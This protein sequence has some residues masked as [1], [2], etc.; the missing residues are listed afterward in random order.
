M[1]FYW[2][3]LLKKHI[4]SLNTLSI[5]KHQCLE[6]QRRRCV[7]NLRD[8]RYVYLLADGIYSS[9]RQNDRLC[10]LLLLDLP[11]LMVRIVCC[12]RR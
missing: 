3:F 5:L 8:T 6:E 10:L 12:V 1:E 11:F 9:V 2:Q 4:V 7:L